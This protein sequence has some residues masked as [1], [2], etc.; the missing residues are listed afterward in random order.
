[1]LLVFVHRCVGFKRGPLGVDVICMGS[2]RYHLK[3]NANSI[4]VMHTAL[5]THAYSSESLV[6]LESPLLVLASA[7]PCQS[8]D[9]PC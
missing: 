2:K 7:S 9:G 6:V 8:I 3:T 1:M 5:K 4:E